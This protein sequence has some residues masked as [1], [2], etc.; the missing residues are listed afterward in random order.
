MVTA[1]VLMNVER[2]RIPVV[3]EELAALSSVSEVYSTAGQFDLA[4]LV[5]VKTNEE[6]ADTVTK[7]FVAVAGIERTE[8]LI[9][10]RTYSRHDI[11][12]IFSIGLEKA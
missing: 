5:R 6:L 7:E 2:G 11:E 1:I 9:S 4:V 10:F 3:A 8:T 12:G